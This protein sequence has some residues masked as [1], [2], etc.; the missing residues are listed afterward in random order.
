MNTKKI[1]LKNASK[2][3]LAIVGFY[4]L[5]KLIGLSHIIELRFLNIVFTIAGM[6]MA[7]KN[8]IYEKKHNN[9]IHNLYVGFS[10]GAYA[11]TAVIISMILYVNFIDTSLLTMIQQSSFWGNHLN[12]T[13]IVFS[14][15]VEGMAACAISTL[16]LMQ[17]WKKQEIHLYS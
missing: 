9:Y 2:I 8:N 4:F 7:I 14:M 5:I 1:I 15:M 11:S 3:Y 6:N 10:T 17:Y 13:K 12:L 16:I